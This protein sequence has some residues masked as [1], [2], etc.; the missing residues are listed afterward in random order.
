MKYNHNC[1]YKN[2][3]S[4]CNYNCIYMKVLIFKTFMEKYKV[5]N[6]TMN[7]NELRRVYNSPL[8]PRDS[9]L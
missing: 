6:N 2:I 3:K 7:E 4:N 1:S 8:Y 9:K 5:I